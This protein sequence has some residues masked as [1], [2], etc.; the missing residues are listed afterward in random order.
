MGSDP[1]GIQ[2]LGYIL[3]YIVSTISSFG[4]VGSGLANFTV[5]HSLFGHET[6]ESRQYALACVMGNLVA[7]MAYNIGERHP[8]SPQRSII[9]WDLI[10]VVMPC[11]MTGAFFGVFV[12]Y[13][14]GRTIFYI[15]ALVMLMSAFISGAFKFFE[16]YRLE[17]LNMA[18]RASQS[19]SDNSHAT[20]FGNHHFR[21]DSWSLRGTTCGINPILLA[22]GKPIKLAVAQDVPVVVEHAGNSHSEANDASL[23]IN[24]DW[25][26]I[27]YIVLVFITFLILIVID[28]VVDSCTVGFWVVFSLIFLAMFVITSLVFRHISLIQTKQLHPILEGD[29]ALSPSSHYIFLVAFIIGMGTS[30]VGISGGEVMGPFF[31]YLKMLPM[32]STA[33]SAFL[34]VTTSIINILTFYL[35]YGKGNLALCGGL[36]AIGIAGGCSGR[37]AAKFVVRRY[38]RS[39][40]LIFALDLVLLASMA[41]FIFYI[42]TEDMHLISRSGI[43]AESSTSIE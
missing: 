12:S 13:W 34:G 6:T 35:L 5:L 14:S 15:L 31:L 28:G 36:I 41:V 42:I 7:Q 8:V 39:S 40:P 20:E 43:C 11:Q 30:L 33:T 9:Y 21:D 37:V 24:F 10:L 16:I 2:A 27:G 23:P 3:L 22:S 19:I 4:G 38:D 1:I 18:V 17:S 32:C 26:I 25:T 29:V